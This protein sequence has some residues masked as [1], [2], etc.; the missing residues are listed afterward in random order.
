M[1]RPFPL[2][3]RRGAVA[4]MVAVCLAALF[5]VIALVLDGCKLQDMK[6]QAQK[7]ADAAALAGATDLF[8]NYNQSQGYD[9]TGT[10]YTSAQTEA[11]NNGF[12]DATGGNVVT[13]KVPGQVPLVGDDSIV[14]KNG[15]LKAGYVEV[16]IVAPQ[17]QFFSTIWGTQ[18]L[19]VKARAVARGKFTS[20]RPGILLLNPT[21]PKSLNATGNGNIYVTGG[22]DIIVD[23]SDPNA[24]NVTGNGIIGAH[25]INITGQNPG[26]SSSGG[27]TFVGPNGQPQAPNTNVPPTPDPFANLPPPSVPADSPTANAPSPGNGGTTTLQ[28]GNYPTGYKATNGNTV[29]QPGIYYLSG[30]GF[31]ITGQAGVTVAQPGSPGFTPDPV[32]GN[33]VLIYNASTKNSDNIAITGTGTV[34]LTAPTQGIYAGLTIFQARNATQAVQIT[35]NG[36]TNI[37]GSVYAAAAQAQ[38]TGN[39]GLN[40]NGSPKDTLGNQFVVDTMTVNGN[41]SFNVDYDSGNTVI[42]RMIGLIE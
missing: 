3:H 34:S 39:G 13:V 31:S 8:V 28:P 5:G 7:A 24:G 37:Q 12:P 6:R 9:K 17:P 2:T 20:A 38:L 27:A 19:S 18:N 32:T 15:K 10:A 16:T 36:Q 23:S 25:Q 22:G 35:G 11:T 42:V 40:G 30:G 4:V 26:Y 21:A 1:I 41:G 29:L 14:D 33:G